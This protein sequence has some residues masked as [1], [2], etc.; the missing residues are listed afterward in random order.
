VKQSFRFAEQEKAGGY[1]CGDV[2]SALQKG[3]RRGNER[4]ALHRAAELALAGLHELCGEATPHHRERGVGPG[5]PM[6][7]VL[8]RTLYENW[9]EQKRTEKGDERHANLFLVHA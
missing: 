8:V 1:R 9:Q 3:I 2:A 5:E 7:P 4:E 6:M